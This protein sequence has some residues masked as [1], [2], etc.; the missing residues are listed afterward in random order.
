MSAHYLCFYYFSTH[1]KATIIPNRILKNAL[2]Y[3][4]VYIRHLS[5]SSVCFVALGVNF[6]L[7]SDFSCLTW[8]TSSM[9]LYYI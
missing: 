4:I 9:C 6:Y 1:L 8:Y 5:C 3:L 7:H 2:R